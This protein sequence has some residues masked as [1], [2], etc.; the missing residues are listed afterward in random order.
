MKRLLLSLLLAAMGFA[1]MPGSASAAEYYFDV[2]CG[3]TADS[4]A[5]H[6]CERGDQIG[7][8][9]ESDEDTEYEVCIEFPNETFACAEEQFAESNVLYVNEIFTE[10]LGEHWASWWIGE[11]LI[12]VWDF[13]VVEPPK[14][15]LAASPPPLAAPPPPP[16]VAPQVSAA[17]LKARGTVRRVRAQLQKARSR[18]R[19]A[20]LRGKLKRARI[21]AR[22][23]C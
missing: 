16:V 20:N 12:G 4:P 2:S 9:F 11:E 23:A 8:F 6:L 14:P 19:K 13:R 7:A 10:Q 21:A 3:L 22:R 5:S 18:K 15:P 17:C 1:L